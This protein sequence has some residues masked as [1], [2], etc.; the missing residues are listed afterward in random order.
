MRIEGTY[1]QN[2]KKELVSSF[3]LQ[4][5]PHYKSIRSEPPGKAPFPCINHHGRIDQC[6]W[7]HLLFKIERSNNVID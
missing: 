3:H 7:L 1:R 6:C 5:D 2:K 4:K